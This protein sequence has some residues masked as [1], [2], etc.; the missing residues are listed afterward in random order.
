M[1]LLY[2]NNL[3]TNKIMETVKDKAWLILPL[4]AYLKY[5]NGKKSIQI[6]WLTKTFHLNF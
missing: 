6:G 3:K 1:Q 4:F 5:S 2:L